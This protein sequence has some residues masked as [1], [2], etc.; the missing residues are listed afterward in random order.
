MNNNNPKDGMLGKAII[1][2]ICV[3]FAVVSFF[4]ISPYF[5]N[6]DNYK[7][8]TESLDDKRESVVEISSV[9]MGLSVA[10]AAIPGDA[11]T[12]IANQI[13]DLNGYLVASLGAIML[14]KFLLPIFGLLTWRILFPIGFILI[15]IFA[16]V[17]K[18]ILI[19]I[20]I[21][22]CIFSLAV[23]LL[24]PAGVLV[25]DVIDRSF[26]TK[27][28]IEEVKTTFEEIDREA[29]KIA[30]ASGS[31]SGNDTSSEELSFWDSLVK[32]VESTVEDVKKSVTKSGEVLL[33]KAKVLMGNLMDIVAAILITCCVV[34]IGIL[35]ILVAIVKTLFSSFTKLVPVELPSPRLPS[36]LHSGKKE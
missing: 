2:A 27:T 36:G 11:T 18:R 17:R 4:V 20:G 3:V 14:E 28:L 33:N 21:K 6:I 19:S 24:I 8:I 12:P 31:S 30:D 35:F 5:E 32:N 23:F 1:T 25:G 9:L 7:P 29:E 34:P 26:G 15:G 22:L 16:I 10:V 13:T